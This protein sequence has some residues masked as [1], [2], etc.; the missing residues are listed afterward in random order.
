MK[1]SIILEKLEKET[2]QLLSTKM[3]KSSKKISKSLSN[4][5]LMKKFLNK[6]QSINKSEITNKNLQQ[7]L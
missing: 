4:K 2:L 7:Q 3:K 6:S 1:K 5:Q